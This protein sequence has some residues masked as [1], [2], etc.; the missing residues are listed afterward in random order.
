[1]VWARALLRAA[2]PGAVRHQSS[3]R[4]RSA[5]CARIRAAYAGVRGS[6]HHGGDCRDGDDLLAAGFQVSAGT[7]VEDGG[8]RRRWRGAEWV[9]LVGLIVVVVLLQIVRD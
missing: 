5:G 1:M 3:G 8:A 2:E 9:A 7:L 6:L 4:P